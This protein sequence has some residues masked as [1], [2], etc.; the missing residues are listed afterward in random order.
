MGFLSFLPSAIGAVS[1]WLGGKS[2]QAGV[3]SQNVANAQQAQKQMDF[4][5]R[6]ANTQEQRRVADL[7]AAGLNPA[8]AYQQGGAAAP[9]G[10]AAVMQNT[11]SGAQTAASG[12]A[13]AAQ[14]A[15]NIK[16][17]LASTAR[18]A[19]SAELADS[20]AGYT[21]AQNAFLQQAE[22][23]LRQAQTRETQQR[24]ATSR[25]LELLQEQNT[26][27][28]AARTLLDQLA[29]PAAQREADF[30]KGWGGAVLPWANLF[31]STAKPWMFNR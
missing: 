6:M 5:E 27:A 31:H 12:V 11:R 18:D 14:S 28:S 17:Q 9:G 16:Q 8:L 30:S 10:S 29:V 13:A 15:L 26:K 7:K 1:S 19:A 20:Q 23:P 4:Q 22:F 25:S 2:Q 24:A 3:Q 21:R